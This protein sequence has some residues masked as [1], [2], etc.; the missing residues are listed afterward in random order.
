MGC[1]RRERVLPLSVVLLGGSILLGKVA[2]GQPW[3]DFLQG[4]FLGLAVTFGFFCLVM[5]A[6]A[7]R[8]E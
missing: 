1:L 7:P 4:M 3:G 6:V 5:A 8:H 2:G